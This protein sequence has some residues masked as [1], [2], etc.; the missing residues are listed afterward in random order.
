MEGE[1]LNILHMNVTYSFCLFSEK[2]NKYKP[3]CIGTLSFD[4]D[5]AEEIDLTASS[6]TPAGCVSPKK[7]S[8]ASVRPID[9]NLDTSISQVSHALLIICFCPAILL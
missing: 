3:K 5:E 2:D 7:V 8:H 9:K 4:S 6:T 1:D